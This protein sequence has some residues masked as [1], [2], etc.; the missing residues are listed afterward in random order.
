[1]KK[2][3][4]IRL[5]YLAGFLCLFGLIVKIAADFFTYHQSLTSAP[6][7]VWVLAD[8]AEMGLPALLFSEYSHLRLIGADHSGFH[9]QFKFT[10][11]ISPFPRN[12]SGNK[13]ADRY[14]VCCQV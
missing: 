13:I 8:C 10:F 12:N 14:M 3:T 9:I 6:F 5:L 4:C 11:H 7:Y 2:Q 1:M